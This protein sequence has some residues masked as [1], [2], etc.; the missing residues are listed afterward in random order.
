MSHVTEEFLR[1]QERQSNKNH[2]DKPQQIK[3]ML[4]GISFNETM[5][6][7]FFLFLFSYKNN[8]MSFRTFIVF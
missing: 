4:C 3:N 5:K 8:K 2:P 1:K 7:K 6:K